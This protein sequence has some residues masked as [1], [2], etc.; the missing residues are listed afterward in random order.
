M[1][2]IAT[3]PASSALITQVSGSYIDSNGVARDITLTFTYPENGDSSQ[4]LPL[5]KRE[6]MAIALFSSLVASPLYENTPENELAYKAVKGADLLIST[7][8]S[9]T[10]P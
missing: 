2:T 8:N 6:A 7:L 5:T 9:V 4:K 10:I 1:A 3:D